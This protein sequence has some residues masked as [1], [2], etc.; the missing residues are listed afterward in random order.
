LGIAL[1]I[2]TALLPSAAH[3]QSPATPVA[4][5][6]AASVEDPG[7]PMTPGGNETLDMIVT[8]TVQS[9]GEPTPDPNNNETSAQPTQVTFQPKT[10]PPWVLSVTFVPPVLNVSVPLPTTGGQFTNNAKVI[11]Q[12][13]PKAPALD[14]KEFVITARAAA[15]G[16]IA[17]SQADSP[18]INLKPAFLAK[19]NVT[20]PT[21]LLVRGGR[22]T[23]VPFTVKNTGN[24]DSN[25]KFNVTA[26]PQDSQVAYPAN[27]TIPA[28]QS[29]TVNVRL[30]IPWTYGEGGAVELQSTPTTDTGDPGK[31]A[32]TDVEVNGQSAVPSLGLGASLAALGLLAAARRRP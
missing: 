32:T 23:D 26:R 8:Y 27:L 15:N 20:A 6:I 2:L 4:S 19:V 12:I 29:V 18:S 25:V 21:T 28:G 13:D 16:N 1:L 17:P 14:K 5:L 11:L 7:H 31:V 30:R 10:V 9:G 22:W 3:A 24:G